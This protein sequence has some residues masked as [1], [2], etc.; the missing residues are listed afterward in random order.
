[1]GRIQGSGLDR[2]PEGLASVVESGKSVDRIVAVT[3]SN[4]DHQGELTVMLERIGGQLVEAVAVDPA[5]TI[6]VPAPERERIT[7]GAR[8]GAPL[9]WFLASIVTGAELFA[10]GVMTTGKAGGLNM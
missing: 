2:K 5:L 3:V 4:G 8:A 7:I 1:V 10:V 6:A 9:L